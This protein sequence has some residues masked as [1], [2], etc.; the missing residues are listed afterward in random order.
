MAEGTLTLNVYNNTA[1]AGEPQAQILPRMAGMNFS[2]KSDQPFS[3]ELVGSLA[4]NDDESYSFACNFGNV[5]LAYLHVDDHMLCQTG[6]NSPRG[7]VAG[8]TDNPVPTMSRKMLPIRLAVVHDGNATFTGASVDIS[9]AVSSINTAPTASALASKWEEN[10]DYPGN[11]LSKMDHVVTKEDCSAL[12][13]KTAGCVA[14]SWDSLASKYKTK[15]CN[16]KSAV[17]QKEPSQGLWAQKMQAII[18][19]LPV[20][21][22]HT[23]PP[24]EVQR[25]QMQ[26]ELLQG[27]GT[28]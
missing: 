7:K 13:A 3:A 11:D 12:C 16:M 21:F 6:T 17:G 15:T 25:R 4:A 2:L 24:T 14:V 18:P 19:G 20:N 5:R 1:F 8:S 10:T 27:W 23:L 26:Q 28:W 9:V 22:T